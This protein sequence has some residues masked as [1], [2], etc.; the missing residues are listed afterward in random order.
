MSTLDPR[1][2]RRKHGGSVFYINGRFL[3]QRVT[4]IQRYAREILGELDAL[5]ATGEGGLGTSWRLVAPKGTVF[6]RL[7]HIRCAH[8]GWLSGHA[9]EQ[10]ELPWVT[11]DGFLVG[12]G[13]AGPWFKR[14]QTIT[15]HDA[16]VCRVP[17]A[18]SWK[19]RMWHRMLIRQVVRRSPRTMV[20]SRFSAREAEACFGA[21]PARLDV[22]CEGWQHMQRADADDSILKAYDL[23][24]R[25]YVLAVSSPT[26]NKNFAVVSEAMQ[27]LADVPFR[28]VV[29]G[30]ADARVFA[31]GPTFDTDRVIRVGYVSD[32]QLRSLYE[33]AFCFVF[34]SKYEGFGIPA[35]EA[36]ALG[37][38]VIASSID[39]L[40]EVCGDAARYFDP[41]DGAALARIIRDLFAS[42]R[43]VARMRACGLERAAAFSWRGSARKSLD[44]IL[45]AT[46]D[47][48]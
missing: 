28:F 13:S 47:S 22:V 3:S 9:W 19:Y 11:R 24:P 25:G 23:A 37:C 20:V 12:F 44:A 16:S 27:R 30:A 33:N 36:M 17:E 46:Q 2:G 34:P 43:E 4:G 26:P 8:H 32:V 14:S 39:A 1:R 7:E 29:A 40:R 5:L 35:L 42:E 45:A 41:R 38:P 31:P 15:V 21:R 6:P 48:V 10:L 18:F